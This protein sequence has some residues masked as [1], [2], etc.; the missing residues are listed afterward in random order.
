MLKFV[1]T[2]KL[3][4][5]EFVELAFLAVLALVLIGMLLGKNAGDYVASVTDNVSKFAA[6]ASSGILG[7]IITLAII[8]LAMRRMK[9]TRARGP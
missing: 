2:A 7:I 8:Y 6:T 3:V 4:L 9:P 1:A 5:W